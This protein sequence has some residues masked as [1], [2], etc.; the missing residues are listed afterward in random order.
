MIIIIITI[1]IIII[2]L[3]KIKAENKLPWDYFKRY[4]TTQT[5]ISEAA[6]SND[7][8]YG[9]G[10]TTGLKICRETVA[11]FLQ[12]K[13]TSYTSPSS[14]LP[15][16]S[17]PSPSAMTISPDHVVIGSGCASLLNQLFFS[18]AEPNDGE[19]VQIL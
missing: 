15:H 11:S 12:R 6:F 5:K 18:L 19:L 2:I 10:D 9:Y 16:L 14:S 13:F 3:W 8:S 17:K 1:I 4:L 7:E